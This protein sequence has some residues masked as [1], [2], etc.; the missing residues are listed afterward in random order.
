MRELDLQEKLASLPDKPGVYIFKDE[1]KE[2][3]YVGKAVSLK[4]RVR[5]YF[6]GSK[7][8]SPKTRRLV[9]HIMDLDYIL[10]DSEVEALILEYNLIKEHRPRYNIRLK[11]DK[12]YPYIKINLN[13]PFSRVLLTRRVKKDGAKYFG[14]YPNVRAAKETLDTLQRI[15]PVRS[16]NKELKDNKRTRPCLNYHI[17][18]CTG[19][20]A[21]KITQ[22]AYSQ[23]VQ[24][25]R[26]FLEGKGNELIKDIRDKMNQASKN[27]D[28]EG[29]AGLRDKL[30]AMEKVLERQKIISTTG[31]DFDFVALASDGKRAFAQVFFVRDGRLTGRQNFTLEAADGEEEAEILSSFLKQYYGDAPFIPTELFLQHQIAEK[32]TI[33][34][35][36]SAEKGC[37]VEIKVPQRGNKK[38][39]LDMAVRNVEFLLGQE[40]IKEEKMIKQTEEAMVELAEVLSIPGPV[41]R[42]EGF[43]I[44]NI[45]GHGAVGSMVV[46]E[47]GLPKPDDYRKFK[48][49]SIKGPDDFAMM[50]E[51]L[52]RRSKHIISEEAL[53]KP[54]LILV[55]GGKGQLSAACEVLRGAGIHGIPIIGLAEQDEE[56]FREGY[57]EPIRLSRE[58]PALQLLQRVR[59]EAHRFA[60]T[61]HRS[62]RRK[63]TLASALDDIPGIGE[64]RRRALLQHF[65][66]V[67]GIKK[68][69][70]DEIM[71]VS[72]MNRTVSKR[73]Y[74][75]LRGRND[76]D[77]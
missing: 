41:R 31:G 64:K 55:D 38:G 5:S 3:L 67:D 4:N 15:F 61:Y 13:E 23:L 24:S 63:R 32:E 74:D 71:K 75:E 73:L 7:D 29:A 35:W 69:T 17:E 52:T 43:D 45:Q 65:G 56:I 48:I 57:S 39:L 28:F 36:L 27:L 46:F 18:R 10:V 9:E 77:E 19:P 54:D 62:L 25:I 26:L 6:Q 30:L 49:R 60:L 58:S 22:E 14:P 16:C 47:D 40:Q 72:G 33:E 21:G 50:R 59:D 2:V 51:V 76:V 1:S 8:H 44:S 53:V 11:D 34:R 37:K 20:C 68:A 42:I 12:S 70:L 66:S